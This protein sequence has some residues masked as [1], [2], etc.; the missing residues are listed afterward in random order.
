MRQTATRCWRCAVPSI[1]ARSTKYLC[2]IDSD[3]EKRQND[4]MQ[5]GRRCPAVHPPTP[6]FRMS[7]RKKFSRS[8]KQHERDEEGIGSGP[9]ASLLAITLW[10]GMLAVC[11]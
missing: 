9:S 3:Y 2:V 10:R 4:R 1:M 8:G 5:G 6:I 7:A 11:V